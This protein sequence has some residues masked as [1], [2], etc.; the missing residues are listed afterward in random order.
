MQR[1]D[2]DKCQQRNRLAAKR[3]GAEGVPVHLMRSPHIEQGG[4][5]LREAHGIMPEAEDDVLSAIHAL[6]PEGSTPVKLEQIYV[7][8]ME[9]ANSSFIP[10]R[11]MFLDETTLRNICEDANAGFAIMNSH[12]TGALSTPSELPFGKT[13]AGRYECWYDP[14]TGAEFKRAVIGCYMLKGIKPN[15]A[16]GPS[17][18][19][20]AAMI[21][22]GTVFDV[23]VG[24]HGGERI[25][26]VCGNGLYAYDR[27]SGEYLCPHA[28]GTSRGMTAS[29]LEAQKARGVPGGYGSYSLVNARCGETSPV[30]DGAVSGAGYRK[31]LALAK[32]NALSSE[33]LGQ[34]RSAYATLLSKGDLEPMDFEELKKVISEGFSSIKESLSRKEKADPQPAPTPAP[35]NSANEALQAQLS[36]MTEL[37]KAQQDQTTALQK[38]LD[39]EAKTNRLQLANEWIT[40]QVRQNRLTA[41]AGNKA[42]QLAA[43]NL[44]A[45]EASKDIILANGKVVMLSGFDT[46]ASGSIDG[47]DAQGA[48]LSADPNAQLADAAMQ[49]SKEQKISYSEAL[50]R[51]AQERPE[52]AAANRAQVEG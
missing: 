36:A 49:L 5:V 3:D 10:G 20:L 37:V 2:R 39:E 32:R 34:A 35:D 23:S 27:T 51:V 41:H 44:E 33:E 43:A 11:W 40:D 46:S 7:H 25:C 9:A 28:P 18:D 26:D 4:L 42:R 38:R 52:L 24:L 48:L 21:D 16:Q 12:R 19:D 17:T 1:F 8:Y 14:S 13:F 30:Y 22:A 45:F 47:D 31:S 29:Q 50:R 6:Q 15:G